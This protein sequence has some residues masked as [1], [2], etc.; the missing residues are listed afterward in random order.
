MAGYVDSLGGESDLEGDEVNEDDQMGQMFAAP[1]GAPRS[2][3]QNFL[4]VV[5][6]KT[7]E[8]FRQDFGLHRAVAYELIGKACTTTISFLDGQLWRMYS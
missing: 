6:E 4:D 3:I 2:P 1:I 8:E 7:D 5:R